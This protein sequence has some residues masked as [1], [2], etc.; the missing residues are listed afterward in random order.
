MGYVYI[1]IFVTGHTSTEKLHAFFSSY[2]FQKLGNVE[3]VQSVP[4][5]QKVPVINYSR[6]QFT[7]ERLTAENFDVCS[8]MSFFE[9]LG[10][11]A[12]GID[13]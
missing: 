8:C 4:K 7:E 12:C 1:I 13:W 5:H 6:S 11:V 2:N 9:W 3:D 10:C